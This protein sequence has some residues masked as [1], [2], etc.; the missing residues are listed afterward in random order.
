MNKNPFIDLSKADRIKHNLD[1]DVFY[2]FDD[3]DGFTTYFNADGDIDC[4]LPTPKAWEW[5]FDND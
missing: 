3:E 1:G 5:D 2:G 4:I